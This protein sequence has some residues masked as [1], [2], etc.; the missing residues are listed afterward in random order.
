MSAPSTQNLTLHLQRD[1]L[2]VLGGSKIHASFE[3]SGEISAQNLNEAVSLYC[4]W[5]IR[6]YLQRQEQQWNDQRLGAA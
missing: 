4:R 6:L 2:N 5:M 1:K 3:T